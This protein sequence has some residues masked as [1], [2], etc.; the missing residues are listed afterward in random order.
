MFFFERKDSATYL[1]VSANTVKKNTFKQEQ[2]TDLRATK[3][4]DQKP[5]MGNRHNFTNDY[6]YDYF[7]FFVKTRIR[8]RLT[9]TFR[10]K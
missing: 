3:S 5:E 9:N 8:L 2:S 4:F 10:R 7:L 6:D 1:K